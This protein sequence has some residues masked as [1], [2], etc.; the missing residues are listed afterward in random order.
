MAKVTF[1]RQLG[2]IGIVEGDHESAAR[3]L[4]EAVPLAR[5]AGDDMELAFILNNLAHVRAEQG[6]YDEALDLSRE[7]LALGEAMGNRRIA[8]AAIAHVGMVELRRGN[9]APA[10]ESF[11]AAQELNRAIGDLEKTTVV[12]NY[13]GNCAVALG[14]ARTAEEQYREALGLAARHGMVP[15]I[16]RAV[17]GLARVADL[18]GDAPSGVRL[19]R[20]VLSHPSSPWEARVVAE[21]LVDGRT[22][23]GSGTAEDLDAVV[24][25]LLSSP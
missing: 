1:L 21:P 13:L 3:H 11:T 9:P 17:A 24:A 16:T 4:E 10:W 18:R 22:G 12:A 6:R 19:A 14:D 23:P 15:E 5:S 7:V 25:E 20:V 2:T 8:M